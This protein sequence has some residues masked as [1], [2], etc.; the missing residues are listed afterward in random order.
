MGLR[1]VCRGKSRGEGPKLTQA[2]LRLCKISQRIWR[3]VI[4]G[5]GPRHEGNLD[6]Y[7][8]GRPGRL[9]TH[10]LAS[11]HAKEEPKA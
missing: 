6:D 7:D 10:W 11:P 2:F 9:R 5:S 1:P 3:G 8:A 4:A